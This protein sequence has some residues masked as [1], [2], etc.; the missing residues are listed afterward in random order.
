MFDL[1]QPLHGCT[2][3][4]TL[5][6]GGKN[7]V[8]VSAA[9]GEFRAVFAHGAAE[10]RGGN[11][12]NICFV[13]G[14]HGNTMASVGFSNPAIPP[15]V[16]TR[17]HQDALVSRDLAQTRDWWFGVDKASGWAFCGAG[18]VI[19]RRMLLCVRVPDLDVTHVCLSN[20]IEPVKLSVKDMAVLPN[21]NSNQ[22]KFDK[23]GRMVRFEG[24]TTVSSHPVQQPLGQAMLMIQNLMRENPRLAPHYSLLP[25]AS[26]HVTTYDLCSCTAAD[27]DQN[28]AKLDQTFATMREAFMQA[29]SLL[30]R[31][32]T[33][34]P[35]GMNNGCELVL[36]DPD[37][38]TAKALAKWR[39]AVGQRLG[40][41]PDPS[42]EF[43]S[44]LAYQM[45]PPN[46]SEAFAA[47][48]AT[49]AA[50][51]AIVRSLGPVTIPAPDFCRFH[52]MGS[53]PP[54]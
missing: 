40:V 16:S 28:K 38:A 48:R 47:F 5:S 7:A 42:Y 15:F 39:S 4:A 19:G 43:H 53:F 23:F 49:L 2:A 12:V 36:L 3:S 45:Y 35:T 9:G 51:N 14:Q 34:L 46:S 8:I 17:E 13:I 24:V 31:T 20:W 33:F 29:R 27:Y 18:N 32:L 41:E 44:T 50:A 26:F 22:K 54:S 6:L 37:D 10:T 25:P 21:L 30:P 11:T 1:P 52:D